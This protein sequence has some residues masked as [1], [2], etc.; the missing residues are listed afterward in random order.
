MMKKKTRYKVL[1][2]MLCLV[3]LFSMSINVF[4]KE[5]SDNSV[6]IYVNDMSK[7]E[8]YAEHMKQIRQ[9]CRELG[10]EDDE[11]SLIA[12][13]DGV[14]LLD[15]DDNY[16]TTYSKT[17]RKTFSGYAGN[18]PSGGT[19]FSTGGGF[20][21]S[22]SGGSTCTL[23]V[24]FGGEYGT[25]SVSVPLGKKAS[26]GYY[27]NVPDKVNYYKLYVSKEYDLMAYKLYHR[28]YDYNT[29][30]YYWKYMSTNVSKI[31]ISQTLSAKK[32]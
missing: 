10:M 31:F 18:Q 28:E 29:D 27:V 12:F 7:E 4:A 32:V 2:L 6:T 8:I 26:S 9:Y 30:S 16:K 21:Y 14:M 20:Y 5:A 22:E 24:G 13:D 1:S 25:I 19:R 3:M 11:N 17:Y 15:Q 23:N